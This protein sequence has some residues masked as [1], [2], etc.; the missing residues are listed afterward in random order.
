MK[1]L[2]VAIFVLLISVFISG[3]GVFASTTRS[4]AGI[5]L[6]AYKGESQYGPAT[7]TSSGQQQYHNAYN[8]NL[9]T[10]N[11]NDVSVRVYSESK[12]YSDWITVSKGS[13]S[14]WEN[15]NKTNRADAY[16]LFIRNNVW[17]IC[18]SQHWGDWYLDI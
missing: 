18:K 17:G 3:T 7:K 16:N 9:C 2:K 15:N 4:Y 8:I 12:K 14:K 5:D 10:S 6:K 13:T 1:G 11:Y